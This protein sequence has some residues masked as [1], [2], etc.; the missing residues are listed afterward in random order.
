MVLQRNGGDGIASGVGTRIGDHGMQHLGDVGAG[1]CVVGG[2]H[3][4]LL[5]LERVIAG[6]GLLTVGSLVLGDFRNDTRA[7]VEILRPRIVLEVGV[8]PGLELVARSGNRR[9]D[10]DLHLQLEIGVVPS[11]VE[12]LVARV[13]DADGIAVDRQV[14]H[15]DRLGG[16]DGREPEGV[17][18]RGVRRNLVHRARDFL[19]LDCEARRKVRAEKVGDGELGGS[20]VLVGAEG[21]LVLVVG[22]HTVLIDGVD[23]RLLASLRD[24]ANR[25]GYRVD[26][27]CTGSRDV[28]VVTRNGHGGRT[29]YA[30]LRGVE[31][32][33]IGVVGVGGVLELQRDLHRAIGVGGGGHVEDVSDGADGIG[34]GI[35]LVVVVLVGHRFVGDLSHVVPPDGVTG[36]DGAGG[37]VRH[38]DVEGDGI[39]GCGLL[40]GVAVD[41]EL[42]AREAG[43]ADL[44]Q[45]KLLGVRL[46]AIGVVVDSDGLGSGGA[47]RRDGLHQ[48]L[49]GLVVDGPVGDDLVLLLGVGVVD[50]NLAV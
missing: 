18:V 20:V 44:L 32:D 33:L 4:V 45:G 23:E 9:I 6:E 15:R 7:A 14:R 11:G 38:L 12:Q 49:R 17:A 26:R 19:D 50:G 41:F 42:P 37:A 21:D 2:S 10:L 35:F 30:C 48:V 29:A 27:V 24:K 31:L 8:V 34:D 13:G 16:V 28:A 22:R 25:V 40:L 5:D 1:S 46:I 3:R 36:D 43:P 47:V 39:D